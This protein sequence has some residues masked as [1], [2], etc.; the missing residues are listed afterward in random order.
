MPLVRNIHQTFFKFDDRVLED[1]PM[2]VS[3]R[4]MYGAMTGWLYRLWN[5]AMVDDVIQERYPHLWEEYC[6]LP[7]QVQRVDMAK[8]IVLD[9]FGGVFPTST[10]YL[11]HLW[12]AY[13]HRHAH[14]IGVLVQ[15]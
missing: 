3:S 13:S 5:E 7:H 2:F 8:Y 11:L 15:T 4:D 9:A 14:L 12:T 10:S 6:A 1:Y